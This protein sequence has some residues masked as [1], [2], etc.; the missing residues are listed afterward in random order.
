[1]ESTPGVGA[2]WRGERATWV[3]DRMDYDSKQLIVSDR[4]MGRGKDIHMLGE[5]AL[6]YMVCEP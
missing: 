4:N 5:G 3:P 6:M 2:S 1:M